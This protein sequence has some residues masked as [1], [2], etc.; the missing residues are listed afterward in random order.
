MILNSLRPTFRRYFRIFLSGKTSI[1]RALMNEELAR[2]KYSG[3]ILDF[4][5]GARAQYFSDFAELIQNG[6]YESANIDPEMMPTYLTDV[7]CRVPVGDEVFDM[8]LSFNTLEYIFDEKAALREFVRVLKTGGQVVLAVPFLF[9]VHGD[10]D[11]HRQT[12]HWWLQALS[13]VG[14]GHVK[15]V[16][17]SWDFMTSGLS[18]TEGGGPIRRL[19]RVVVPLYGLIYSAIRSF[20]S[21]ERYK[22]DVAATINNV[23]LGYVITG[24]KKL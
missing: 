6:S 19:R 24:F 20:G 15:I 9:R 7:D 2:I 22:N 16:P 5:G 14:I 3:R 23:A 10:T 21:G 4:G 1:Y 12:A 8:V 17:L 13:D 11:Y 18:V